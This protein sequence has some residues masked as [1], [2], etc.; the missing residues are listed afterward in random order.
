MRNVLSILLCAALLLTAAPID[1]REEAFIGNRRS[2]WAF[3]KV[4]RPP[5]PAGAAN[6][7]DAFIR[8]GLKPRNLSP[9][10]EAGKRTLIR[11]ATFDLT[12]LPPT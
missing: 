2:Y 4:V 12:G 10:P 7:I 8:E 9:S 5:V 11:R 3:Q 6:P 1:P